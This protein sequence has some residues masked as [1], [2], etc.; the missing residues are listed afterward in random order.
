MT[1]T[2]NAAALVPEEK[3]KFG[4]SDKTVTALTH[5]LIAR[6]ISPWQ[7]R[8]SHED[9]TQ[10]GRRDTGEDAHK[11]THTHKSVDAHLC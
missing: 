5:E 2:Q 11:H 10:E 8:R 7:R 3:K 1:E 9:I 6:L 4:F